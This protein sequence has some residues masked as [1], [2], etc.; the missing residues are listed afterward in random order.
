MKGGLPL[1]NRRKS[2]RDKKVS[3]GVSEVVRELGV[4]SREPVKQNY[5][6]NGPYN[7]S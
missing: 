1:T 5:D 2:P 6:P 3:L 4:R 7:F